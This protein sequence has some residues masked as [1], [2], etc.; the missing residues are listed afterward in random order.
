MRKLESTQ[1]ET[2]RL[3]PRNLTVNLVLL[4]AHSLITFS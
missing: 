3:I 2:S 4:I 1:K